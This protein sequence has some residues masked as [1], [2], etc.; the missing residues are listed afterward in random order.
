[1]SEVASPVA[2][3]LRLRV[4]L[5]LTNF[6]GVDKR[7]LDGLYTL[8]IGLVLS[9]VP[10]DPEQIHSRGPRSFATWELEIAA[11]PLLANVGHREAET[12]V[13]RILGLLTCTVRFAPGWH[14]IHVDRWIDGTWCEVETFTFRG[15]EP[16]LPSFVP[17]ERMHTWSR[18]L[19][20]WPLL[21]LDPVVDRALDLHYES[22]ELRRSRP[23]A[24]FLLALTAT[25]ALLSAS[26]VSD[27][28]H[29]TAVRRA[30][31][32]LG[33]EHADA[34]GQTIG[35]WRDAQRLLVQ[36]GIESEE[37]S[38]LGLQRFLMRALPT[39]ARVLLHVGRDHSH[40]IGW[41]DATSDDPARLHLRQNVD[42][43]WWDYLPVTAI[44]R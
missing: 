26:L 11:G 29:E 5:I 3:G 15:R 2:G 25:E 14:Q 35:L 4:P 6:T 9:R 36:R 8:G 42:Q 19:E 13:R 43:P 12:L 23:T 41:L 27:A 18:L 30:V 1:M 31:T 7:P 16:F 39:M 37:R 38:L 32:L 33:G 24:A 20:H 44:I 40:A 21:G 28:E 17:E 22:I 10:V 34:L